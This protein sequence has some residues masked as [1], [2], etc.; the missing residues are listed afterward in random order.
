MTKKS[1]LLSIILLTSTLFANQNITREEEKS[2]KEYKEN[3]LLMEQ[4]YQSI[5]KEYDQTK[6]VELEANIKEEMKK[7]IENCTK[8]KKHIKKTLFIKLE[9]NKL[10]NYLKS[11]SD[12]EEAYAIASMMFIVN[13]SKLINE[14]ALEIQTLEEQENIEAM[15]DQIKNLVEKIFLEEKSESCE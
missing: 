9:T 2:L 8:N 15:M 4:L 10:I 1:L 14:K 6:V 12:S 7:Y 3:M 5:T 11:V 13:W